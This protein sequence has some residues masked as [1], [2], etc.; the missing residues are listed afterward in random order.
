M[1]LFEAALK[2]TPPIPDVQ[3]AAQLELAMALQRLGRQQEAIPWFQQV[4]EREPKNESALTNLGL[5]LTLTGNAKGALEILKRANLRQI[6]R[7]NE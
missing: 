4:V 1:P 2:T 5:A 3:L 7:I 6:A